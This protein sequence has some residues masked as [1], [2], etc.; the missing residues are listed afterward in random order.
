MS[1]KRLG[2]QTATG[3]TDLGFLYKPR[4]PAQVVAGEAWERSRILLLLGPAGT[5]KTAAA[6]GMGLRE[7]LKLE[8]GFLTLARPMVTCDEDPGFLPGDLAA[9][10]G[11]WMAPFRDVFSTLATADWP[12]LE[13]Q[14]A[15]RIETVPVGMLRGRTI[16]NGVLI[17]DEIQNCTKSQLKC[18]LTRIGDPHG[19]VIMCGDPEQSDRFPAK[20]SPLNEIIRKLEGMEDFNV[21]QFHKTNDQQRSKIVTDVLNRLGDW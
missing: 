9:K 14:L 8:H 15:E 12:G 16:R 11:P 4:G 3:I 10:L 5:G 21:V 2:Q 7:V 6:F 17:C 13:R 20:R 1:K 19:R 18:I